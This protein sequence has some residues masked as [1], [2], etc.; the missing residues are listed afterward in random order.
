MR[1]WVKNFS[2]YFCARSTCL[3]AFISVHVRVS[4]CG[5]TRRLLDIPQGTPASSGEASCGSCLV[6]SSP[7]PPHP[8]H[9]P[10][11]VPL[12]APSPARPLPSPHHNH[13][14]HHHA[15][16]KT[17]R[18]HFA[19]RLSPYHWWAICCFS[20]PTLLNP[21]LHRDQCTAPPPPCLSFSVTVIR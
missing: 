2:S 6:S 1:L 14:N 16:V 7:S 19:S 15:R 11:P 18:S 21:L 13:H 4:V 9:Q 12:G 3:C 17:P 10:L 8:M 20:Q 5:C